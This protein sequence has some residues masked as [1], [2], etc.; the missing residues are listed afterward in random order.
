MKR[1][2]RNIIDDVYSTGYYVLA[3]M[4]IISAIKLKT[5]VN[6][7]LLLE[8]CDFRV[9]IGKIDKKQRVLYNKATKTPWKKA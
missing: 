9:K 2:I 7:S 4:P 6:M 5:R 8:G 3:P 1:N